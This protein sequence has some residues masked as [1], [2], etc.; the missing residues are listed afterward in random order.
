MFR[1]NNTGVYE[2]DQPS[3]NRLWH[4]NSS[5]TGKSIK[6]ETRS[7][8]RSADRARIIARS[9]RI[10]SMSHIEKGPRIVTILE[11][12]GLIEEHLAFE[13]SKH[14]YDRDQCMFV[15][16]NSDVCTYMLQ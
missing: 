12:A 15:R 2:G 3:N 5:F 16:S 7:S 11:T 13:L 4:D 9:E 10:A 1:A 8:D 14:G 6:Q